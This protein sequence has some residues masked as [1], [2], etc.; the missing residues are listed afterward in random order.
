MS[1]EPLETQNSVLEY[2]SL[3][4]FTWS[5]PESQISTVKMVPQKR[6]EILIDETIGILDLEGVVGGYRD[7]T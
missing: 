5:W 6:T 1:K 4:C 2:G 3:L 7:D